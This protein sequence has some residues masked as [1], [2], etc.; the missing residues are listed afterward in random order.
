MSGYIEEIGNAIPLHLNAT[1]GGHKSAGGMQSG[2]ISLYG[3]NGFNGI[4][5]NHIITKYD[6]IMKE[7]FWKTMENFDIHQGEFTKRELLV[8]GVVVPVV[9]VAIMGIAG[10]LETLV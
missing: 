5:G 6:T 2:E 3:K 7:N 4:Y 9:L 8:Y 10:W 1:D